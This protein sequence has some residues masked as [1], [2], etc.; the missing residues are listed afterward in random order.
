MRYVDVK[1]TLDGWTY[2]GGRINAYKALSS[3]LVPMNLTATTDTSSTKVSLNWEDKA[4]GEGGYIVERSAGGE[5][6]TAIYQ[7]PSN[8]TSYDDSSVAATE[9]YVYRIKAFNDFAESFPSN[10]VSVTVPRK[11]HGGG[12]GGCSIGAGKNSITALAD[13]TV[14]LVPLIFIAVMRRRR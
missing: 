1:P 14:L 7:L 13:L 9:S 6:F 2:T 8:V 3:L 4:T 12:G 10:E 11:R 5:P